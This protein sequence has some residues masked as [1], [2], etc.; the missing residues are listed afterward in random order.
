MDRVKVKE[1][2]HRTPTVATGQAAT[3]IGR[4]SPDGRIGGIQPVCFRWP[5]F[6]GHQRPS[7]RACLSFLRL[8]P[9]IHVSSIR[10][11]GVLMYPRDVS[12]SVVKAFLLSPTFLRMQVASR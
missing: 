8:N 10:V 7:V 1:E 2:F 5:G 12:C 4:A 11:T 3:L 9:A 6:D